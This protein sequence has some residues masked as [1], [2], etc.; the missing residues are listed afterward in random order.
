MR[1]EKGLEVKSYRA[2]LFCWKKQF[3]KKNTRN[4]EYGNVQKGRYE[5]VGA[6]G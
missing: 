6:K 2:Y 1:L 5:G 4:S 3:E